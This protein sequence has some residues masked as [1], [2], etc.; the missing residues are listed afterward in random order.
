MGV[1]VTGTLYLPDDLIATV[2]TRVAR[3]PKG[4]A[5]RAFCNEFLSV[6]SARRGKARFQIAS[7]QASQTITCTFASAVS[8]TDLIVLGGTTLTAK[9]TPLSQADFFIG[10]TDATMAASL[11]AAINA[12][13]TL[14]KYVFAVVTT[15]ASGIVTVYSITP[16]LVGNFITLTKTGNGLAVGGATLLGGLSDAIKAYGFGWNSEAHLAG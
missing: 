11:A 5:V 2:R 4:D 16:G 9:T 1:H 8:A 3:V 12:H 15:A 6:I 7:A 14:S 13:T 10:T